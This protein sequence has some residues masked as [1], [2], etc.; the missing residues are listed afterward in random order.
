MKQWHLC[1][2]LIDFIRLRNVGH[3]SKILILMNIKKKKNNMVLHLFSKKVETFTEEKELNCLFQMLKEN[4]DIIIIMDK[5]AE[6][7]KKSFKHK[8]IFPTPCSIKT[9]KLKL[10]F[11]SSL[12]R[13]THLFFILKIMPILECVEYLLILNQQ[14]KK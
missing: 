9:I 5:I 3:F 11:I 2:I 10:E 13:L 12:L 7:N 6:K 14:K 1:L 8:H 4:I